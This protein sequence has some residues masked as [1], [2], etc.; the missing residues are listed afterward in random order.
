M[1]NQTTYDVRGWKLQLWII[2]YIKGDGMYSFKVQALP[3]SEWKQRPAYLLSEK[4]QI[5]EQNQTNDK[6]QVN[7]KPTSDSKGVTSVQT[8][9]TFSLF[10]Q[11]CFSS[12]L[13]YNTAQIVELKKPLIP[14]IKAQS[15]KAMVWRLTALPFSYLDN[16]CSVLCRKGNCPLCSDHIL[17]DRWAPNISKCLPPSHSLNFQLF[18]KNNSKQK[19]NCECLLRSPSPRKDFPSFTAVAVLI[20]ASYTTVL[21]G[22]SPN[23]PFFW[24]TNSSV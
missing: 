17:P 8:Q 16:P 19:L 11:L 22:K 13:P 15:N 4:W 2:A 20:A 3:N 6:T 1:N 23:S 21:Q 12:I 9:E 14:N 24:E 7:H 18:Q 10:F 5:P